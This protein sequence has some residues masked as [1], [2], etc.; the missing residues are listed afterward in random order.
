M[1]SMSRHLMKAFINIFWC[2]FFQR[3]HAASNRGVGLSSLQQETSACRR[4]N[5][6]KFHSIRNVIVTRTGGWGLIARDQRWC[7][8]AC[9]YI[10]VCGQAPIFEHTRT[11]LKG[12]EVVTH[13]VHCVGVSIRI[14][15]HF[16][17]FR[18]TFQR[19]L[20]ERGVSALRWRERE[21]EKRG[22]DGWVGSGECRQSHVLQVTCLDRQERDCDLHH[23]TP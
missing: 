5:K 19:G 16:C 6:I 11:P 17:D 9:V 12:R 8:T 10:R 18:V 20:V 7:V 3:R 14:E 1:S 21:R 2:I 4:N 23:T 13:I 22:G 15:K